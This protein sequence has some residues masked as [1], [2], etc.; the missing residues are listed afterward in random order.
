MFP[1]RLLSHS[2]LAD[3]DFLLSMNSDLNIKVA[4]PDYDVVDSRGR[5][6]LG[7]FADRLLFRSFGRV[8]QDPGSNDSLLG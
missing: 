8:F 3:I 2:E 7:V 4:P 6:L 5:P 1:D